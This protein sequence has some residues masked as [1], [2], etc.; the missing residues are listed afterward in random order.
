MF[1]GAS[2]DLLEN[3]T[4]SGD[5]T[6][7]GGLSSSLM[8]ALCCD[9]LGWPPRVWLTRPEVWNSHSNQSRPQF[10]SEGLAP[11]TKFLNCDMGF[12]DR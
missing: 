3:V 7:G 12:P 8:D 1:T 9:E 5:L 2:C 6:L 4:S 11:L 10:R